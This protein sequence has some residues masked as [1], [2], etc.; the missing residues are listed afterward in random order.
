MFL[1]GAKNFF[2]LLLLLFLSGCG[3]LI[4]VFN[5]EHRNQEFVMANLDASFAGLLKRLRAAE[6]RQAVTLAETRKQIAELE[7]LTKKK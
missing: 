2:V 7:E 6:E 3:N 4:V 5:F 1:S